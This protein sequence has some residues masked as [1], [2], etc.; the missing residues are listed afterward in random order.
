MSGH[1]VDGVGGGPSRRSIV[2]IELEVLGVEVAPAQWVDVAHLQVPRCRIRLASRLYRVGRTQEL[3]H[4]AVVVDAAAGAS[5]VRGKVAHLN[6][7]STLPVAKGYRD[8]FVGA[9]ALLKRDVPEPI[10]EGVVAPFGEATIRAY[11]KILLAEGLR[12]AAC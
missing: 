6:G 11:L 2:N 10:V 4:Q 3:K 5:A 8:G 12:Q 9:Q 7:F 1:L